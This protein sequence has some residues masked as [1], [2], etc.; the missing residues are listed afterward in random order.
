MDELTGR[1]PRQEKKN[2]ANWKKDLKKC[3]IGDGKNEREGKKSAI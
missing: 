2:L 3:S 1:L